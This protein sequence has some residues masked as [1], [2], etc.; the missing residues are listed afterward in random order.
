MSPDP[1]E[2]RAFAKR[3]AN[4]GFS[5]LPLKPRAKVPDLPSWGE[6]QKRRPTDEEA[7]KWFSETRNL[8]V[9]CGSVSGGLRVLDFESEDAFVYCFGEIAEI[10]R[11]TP[12]SSTGRG[13]H[14][15]TRLK[16]GGKP[17][18][19]TYQK[20]GDAK[21]WLPLDVQGEGKYVVGPPSVH[22][23]GR[24]Y[25]FVSEW[26]GLLEVSDD[27][28]QAE[29]QKRAEEWPFVEIILPAWKEGVRQDLAL[30]L[31][32][33]LRSRAGFAADRIEKVVSRICAVTHDLEVDS[34]VGAV[35]ATLAKPEDE[36]A[37]EKWLRDDLYRSLKGR[38]PRRQAKSKDGLAPHAA[39][40]ER[41][42]RAFT[43]ATMKDTGEI[44]VYDAGVYLPGAEALIR[45]NVETSLF[46]DG[47]SAKKNLREETVDAIRA[48][49]YV[50]RNSFNPPGKLCLENG[51]L[52]LDG[53]MF[54]P[55][56]R[57]DRFTRKVPVAYDSTA[58]CPTWLAALERILP[59]SRH[60]ETL[61]RLFG[62]CLEAGNP[63]QVAFMAFG[64]GNNGK[65]TV[66]GCLGDL[67]GKDNIST[68]TLQTLSENRFAA[69]RLWD[70]LANICADIPSSIVRYTGTFKELTGG[71]WMRGE[72]KFRPSFNFRNP[73]KL[74]FS[75]NVLPEVNDRTLAFWRR[76]RLLPFT[77]DL[78]GQE[79]R[80]LPDKLRAE[81]P[82]ILNWSLEGL[83]SLRAAG[84]FPEDLSADG[85]NE[86]WK[87]RAD[88]L[89]WFL[90]EC[91]NDD[92][93][94][95]ITKDDFYSRYG[96]FCQEHNLKGSEKARV[97]ERLREL[98]P[99]VKQERPR[100]GDKREWVWTGVAWNDA[101]SEY[102][103]N[104]RHPGPPGPPRPDG[105]FG[106]G[107][108]SGQWASLLGPQRKLPPS[109]DSP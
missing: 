86:E 26:E 62:Y 96:L 24:T 9:V 88:P 31:T 73:A 75:A 97:G 35:H 21:T 32:A 69:G 60:R 18:S 84:S 33:M 99:A 15:W 80:T 1:S 56:T 67:L 7:A 17:K 87:R 109:E 43:F 89:Y 77:V 95:T 58:L 100:A 66:L 82:G 64:P 27:T 2:L 78:S 59:E 92:P 48:R 108:P 23:N 3:Y 83:R 38:I 37:A 13:Y 4:L 36:I 74:V 30:G 65:S 11:H 61:Q 101:A 55:H 50:D 41:L 20:K 102:G 44:F 39:H 107:G 93:L 104:Y 98:R 70:K 79:D 52:S 22:P 19:T 34:R 46:E 29:L 12:V 81:L 53:P 71:D 28:L 51:V 106:Q 14:L 94:G 5:F 49:T 8:G 45:A 16:G 47:D 72:E 103:P 105:D 85:L 25:S 6:Y 68:E 54:G 91:T 90:A 42:M 40:V 10:A 63:Y 57:N 76:W